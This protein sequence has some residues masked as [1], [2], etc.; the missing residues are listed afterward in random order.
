MQQ[1]PKGSWGND[2]EIV[3]ARRLNKSLIASDNQFRGTGQGC[4]D[5]PTVGGIIRRPRGGSGR[6][7]HLRMLADESH[8]FL[9]LIIRQT[10]LASQYAF[11]FSQDRLAKHKLVFGKHGSKNVLAQ[12]AGGECSHQNV[13]IKA[14]LSCAGTPFPVA[15]IPLMVRAPRGVC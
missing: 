1:I 8:D 6:R 5:Y 14:K 7:D 9:N 12:A 3:S 13:G 4:G 2:F 15:P 10:E 11:E